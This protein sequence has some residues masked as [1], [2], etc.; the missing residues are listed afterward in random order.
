M[1]ALVT[2]ISGFTGANL[3]KALVRKGYEVYGFARHSSRL[4]GLGDLRLPVHRGDL[5]DARAVDQAVQGMDLVFHIAASFREPGLPAKAYYDANVEGTRCV[6]EAAVHHGVKRLIH[7][8]TM[9]V[10]GH[11]ENPPGNEESP[12]RPSDLYQETKLQGEQL[13]HDYIKKGLP[14]VIFRPVGIYGPGDTRFL[15]LFRAVKNGIFVM[16][17]DGQVLFQMIYIDDLVE[18]IIACAENDNALGHVFIIAGEPARPLNEIVQS[19]ARILEVPAPKLR[20][21]FWILWTAS[22]LC[23]DVCKPFGIT[24]PLFRR[25]ANFFRKARAFDATKI[26]TMLGVKSQV[27]LEEGFRRTAAWFRA[28]HLL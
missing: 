14:A 8:S 21:P 13:V 15:K 22:V 24:P 2:G 28:Q 20:L 4:D 9:G 11:V 10:H 27:S 5:T 18:A 7:C 12:F 23:E 3:A 19:I 26:E 6:L 16:F 25:R 17:G 1:K